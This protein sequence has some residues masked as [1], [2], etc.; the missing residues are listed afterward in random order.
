MSQLMGIRHNKDILEDEDIFKPNSCIKCKMKAYKRNQEVEGLMLD[1]MSQNWDY[2]KGK[3]N[4]CLF[5]L[6]VNYCRMNGYEERVETNELELQVQELFLN[7]ITRLWDLIQK[8]QE[9]KGEDRAST[10]EQLDL[11]TQKSL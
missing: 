8:S 3:W 9:M 2:I 10:K 1:P 6:F 11:K 4:E 7:C 5:K